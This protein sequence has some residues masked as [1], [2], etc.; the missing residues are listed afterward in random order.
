M[1]ASIATFPHRPDGRM[2]KQEYAA[3]M[4]KVWERMGMVKP[5]PLVTIQ[6]KQIDKPIAPIVIDLPPVAIANPSDVE[7]TRVRNAL[8]SG[9][10]LRK[11]KHERRVIKQQEELSDLLRIGGADLELTLTVHRKPRHTEVVRLVANFFGE[12]IEDITSDSRKANHVFARHISVYLMRKVGLFSYPQ[13][14]RL[15]GKDHSTIISS[16]DKVERLI[17]EDEDMR[18]AVGCLSRY[19]VEAINGTLKKPDFYWGA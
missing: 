1:T 19:L 18:F 13:I 17:Q 15:F 10:K 9:Y 3:H 16:V 11:E 8:K 5:A 7:K 14:G 6:P 4:K 2:T 12:S